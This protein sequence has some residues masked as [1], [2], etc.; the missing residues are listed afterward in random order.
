ML[1]TPLL[2]CPLGEHDLQA[3][4]FTGSLLV[5]AVPLS[6]GSNSSFYTNITSYTHVQAN[7]HLPQ[8]S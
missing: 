7:S 5:I 8:F 4:V 1:A 2:A 3:V 6:S